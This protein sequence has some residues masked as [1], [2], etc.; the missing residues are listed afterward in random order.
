MMV[1]TK[2]KIYNNYGIKHEAGVESLKFYCIRFECS[3]KSLLYKLNSKIDIIKDTKYKFFNK[4]VINFFSENKGLIDVNYL[5]I[6]F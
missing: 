2:E 6:F 1:N 4:G 3:L 5:F